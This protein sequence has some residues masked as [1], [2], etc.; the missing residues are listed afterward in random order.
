MIK[1]LHIASIRNNPFNGVCVAVPAHIIHQSDLADVALLNI[2]DCKIEGIDKQFIYK[3]SNWINDISKDFKRP[4]IVVF[5]EVYYIQFIK[6]ASSLRKMNIPYVILPH[7]A[8][9][10]ASQHVKRWKKIIANTFFFYKFIYNASAIQCLSENEYNNTMFQVD[11]FIASNGIEIPTSYKKGFEK[12]KIIISYIGRLQCHVK[13]LDLL[14]DAAKKIKQFLIKENVIFEIYGPDKF[15]WKAQLHEM[16]RENN[17]ENIFRIHNA[18]ESKEK[19]MVLLQ[20]DLFIQTSRH[21][22][23]TMGLLEA[24]SIGV[25][26]LVTVGTSLGHIIKKYNAGWVAENSVDSICDMIISAIKEKAIWKTKSENAR[27]LTKKEYSW[28]IIS[29]LTISKYKKIIEKNRT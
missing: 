3:G 5:H 1:I 26:C 14:I 16:V 27:L 13:G 24:L 25:P 4:D 7:G 2:I 21:E 23:M 9:V 28:E 11:K 18:V 8:L 17:V 19:Q 12:D 6:I 20:T 15:G 10:K 22:G 29:K